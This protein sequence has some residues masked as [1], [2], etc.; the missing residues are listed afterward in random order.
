MKP[1]MF[2]NA[3]PPLCGQK[4]LIDRT[5]LTYISVLVPFFKMTRLIDCFLAWERQ[6]VEVPGLQSLFRWPFVEG[7]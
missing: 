3:S 7:A 6:S 1:P 5:R 4:P 2:K